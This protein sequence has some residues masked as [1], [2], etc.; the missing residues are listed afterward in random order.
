MIR[1]RALAGAAG[2]LVILAAGCA[3]Y[4]ARLADLRPQLAAGAYDDALATVEKH[5][6]GKDVLLAFLERGLI[7]HYAGRW[8]ESNDAFAAA[9]RTADELYAKS[10]SEGAF[11]LLTNDLSISYRARPFELAMVPYY[12]ALNYVALGLRDDA[13]VEARKSSLLLAAYVDASIKGVERGETGD[14]ARTKNDPF[15][16]YFAGML[17][18]WDGEL[19]DA[20]IAYRNAATAYQDVH[21]L[22]GLEIPPW[23]GRDLARCAA[24]L[25]FPEELAQLRDA[26]PDVF[27]AAGEAPAGRE[28]WA[29]VAGRGEV[30]LLVETGFVPAKSE[31]RLD[32]P[33]LESD[34]YD[35]EEDWA[36]RIAERSAYS[37]AN[38]GGAEIAY[39]LA[40]AVPS[41]KA[42][43]GPVQ[44]VRV[45]VA[46]GGSV[47]GVRAHHPAAAAGITFDAE[48]GTILVKTIVRGLAKYLAVDAVAGENETF[49]FL[50]NLFTAATE[51]AD[52]RGWLTLPEQVQLIRLSLPAGVHNLSLELL[53]ATGQAIGS[54]TLAPVT[55]RAGDWTFVSRRVF[56]P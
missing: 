28:D 20:F 44:N 47:A 13:L 41:L 30:V 32:L 1:P 21:D 38:L 51:S 31:A 55:V 45:D 5:A 6:G 42:S 2:V 46:G 14:L 26:C 24:R 16:L 4:T 9:E 36:Y 17:Y 53:D 49:G 52:T 12:R 29:W 3:T 7:L 43:P 25:G 8:T 11:S 40:I 15:M 27:A 23:L 19:N 33:I 50:A 37:R 34:D 39:W 54:E 18:D 56:A 22:L 10:L 48:Y 35:D